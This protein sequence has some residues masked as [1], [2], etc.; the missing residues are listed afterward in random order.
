MGRDLVVGV[1]LGGTKLLAGA[2]DGDGAVHHRALRP[3]LGVGQ[4]ELLDGCV[5][6]VQEARE[7][8][9]GTV[10]GVGFGI[11]SLVDLERGVSLASNHLPLDGVPFRDLME[12]RLGLPVRVDNDGNATALVE[13]RRGA[14]AGHAHAIVLTIGTGI[15]GGLVLGGELYRGPRGAAGE[16]GHVPVDADGPP[17]PGEC[18]GRGCLEAMV[19]GPALARE[20]VRL[21]GDHP[22]SGLARSAQAGREVTGPLVTELAADGDPCAIE[23][24]R[25]V[26][27]WLGVGLAGIVNVF[28]PEVVVV[29]GGV[30]AAGELLLGPARVEMEARALPVARDRVELRAARFGH[31]AGMLGAAELAWDGVREA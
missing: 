12:E 24:L 3:V 27:T 7:S 28:T 26:G 25:V 13:H 16:L 17:C 31:E 8:I 15:G 5:E 1:D 19:S 20:A 18:P 4:R 9:D 30:I 21:A 2:V 10:V 11:P 23:A 29:G 6:A 22:E 14:A